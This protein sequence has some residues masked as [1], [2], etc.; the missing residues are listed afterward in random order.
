MSPICHPPFFRPPTGDPSAAAWAQFVTALLTA[1]E[2]AGNPELHLLDSGQELIKVGNRRL[3]CVWSP[4]GRTQE[5]P[6]DLT[7]KSLRHMA[8]RRRSD[9]PPPAICCNADLSDA[10][11][12]RCRK[13]ISDIEL[14]TPRHWAGECRKFST[15]SAPWFRPVLPVAEPLWQTAATD[16]KVQ[17]RTTRL[18]VFNWRKPLILHIHPRFCDAILQVTVSPLMTV[19]QLLETLIHLLKMP[20]SKTFEEDN[21]VVKLSWSLKY[22][23][24]AA[25][26]D[27]PLQKLKVQPETAIEVDARVLM[28]DQH[29]QK[30]N[31]HDV[32]YCADGTW[33]TRSRSD[34]FNTAEEKFRTLMSHACDAS[35]R[36]IRTVQ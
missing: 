6:E 30:E 9:S 27:T 11:R 34:R 10:Q 31:S 13:I 8:S 20:G 32:I 16:A 17:L 2:P 14:L 25:L 22:N 1:A 3:L 23:N 26:L 5:V 28:R 12:A 33:H 19:D 4:T 35:L 15:V 18:T 29:R 21:C 36:Q 7:Q 24:Q